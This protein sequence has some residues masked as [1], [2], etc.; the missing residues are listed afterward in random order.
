M[1]GPGVL[2]SGSVRERI[3]IDGRDI[4][5]SEAKVYELLKRQPNL[6][7]EELA[8]KI[9]KTVKL[10]SEPKWAEK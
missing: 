1:I 3:T 8:G 5:P 9:G 2:S 6:T 4:T 10:C 7:R